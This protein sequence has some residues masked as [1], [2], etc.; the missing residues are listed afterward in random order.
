MK[1]IVASVPG[2]GKTTILKFVKKKLSEAKIVN[3]GDLILKISKNEF[4]IKDRDELRKKL[5]LEQQKYVQE[6]AAKKIAQMKAKYLFIDTH[7]SIKTPHGYFPGLSEKTI[8]ILKPDLIIVLE[9]P[10]KDI[11]E[12]RLK[13]KKRKRDIESLEDIEEH[14]KVNREFA[15]S[16]ATHVQS[17]VEIISFKKQ[18]KKPLEHAKIAAE[19]IV[20][21]VRR[22]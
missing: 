14:Q 7:I 16:A 11:F 4:G 15:L 17:A 21:I 19:K 10:A 8:H 13:D 5:T 3:M 22:K 18:Q 12:R 6:V 1:I 2:A 9:F 20:K